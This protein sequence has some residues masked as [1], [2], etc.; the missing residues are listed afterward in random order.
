MFS[1]D[2]IGTN[3]LFDDQA[4]KRNILLTGHTVSFPILKQ[5]SSNIKSTYGVQDIHDPLN[6]CYLTNSLT[7]IVFKDDDRRP[8]NYHNI[9]P[10]I[11]TL[12]SNNDLQSLLIS[13]TQDKTSVAVFK[14]SPLSYSVYSSSTNNVEHLSISDPP[15][16][17]ETIELTRLSLT[18][19]QAAWKAHTGAYEF[20]ATYYTMPAVQTTQQLIRNINKSINDVN[21]PLPPN[22]HLYRSV[23]NTGR[24][25]RFNCVGNEEP[26]E[27]EDVDFVCV[28][29]TLRKFLE[30]N[31]RNMLG[32]GNSQPHTDQQTAFH[33]CWYCGQNQARNKIVRDNLS[34]L[35]INIM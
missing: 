30:P 7:R 3:V 15:I 17:K 33:A 5:I 22:G 4:T 31:I 11:Q 23:L 8:F 26:S 35:R 1:I 20:T 2:N 32:L 6:W 10:F 29:G 25:G 9:F 13:Y 34:R 24:E 12:L 14:S 28:R 18:S 16:E 19:L 27:G 21:Q